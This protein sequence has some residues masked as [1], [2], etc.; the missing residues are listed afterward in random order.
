[1]ASFLAEPT[2]RW[3]FSVDWYD[4]NASLTRTYTLIY[5]PKSKEVEMFDN[6]SRRSFLRKTKTD[7]LNP[8][9]L[10]VGSS[11]SLLGRQLTVKEYA[12]DYTRKALTSR[13]EKCVAIVNE[14]NL[15]RMGQFLSTIASKGN[16]ILN[17]QIINVSAQLQSMLS[18]A[19][20]VV[21]QGQALMIEFTSDHLSQTLEQAS[22]IGDAFCATTTS[23]STLLAHNM[24]F[25]QQRLP[26]TAVL[27]NST[28]GIVKPH[29]VLDGHLGAIVADIQQAG[30]TIAAMHSFTLNRANAEEFLEVYKGVV[31]EYT[32]LVTEMESGVCIA[33]EIVGGNDVHARFR[34][35]CGPMDPEVARHLRPNTLRAKY[36]LNKVQ[37]A[38]HCTDLPE[39]AGLETEYFFSILLE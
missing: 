24:C 39:D 28:L 29:A 11:F 31:P 13:T 17:L 8:N 18:Q 14:A 23:D 26:T 22:R 12:D 25:A 21:T 16:L 38:V 35:L 19:L 10:T 1:M 6:K 34:Q 37:S 15:D 32:S 4:A 27:S 36:G 7:S 20:E 30:L 33:M 2:E 3:A 9:V 5:Y